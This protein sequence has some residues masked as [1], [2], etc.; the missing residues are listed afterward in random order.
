V[1][2]PRKFGAAAI[3]TIGGDL[4][5][6]LDGSKDQADYYLG[7]DG[8]PTH[9]RVELHGR[10]FQRLGI[11]TLD[12]TSFERLAAGHHPT[13]GVRLV[14]TSHIPTTGLNPA[15]GKPLVRGGSHVP[16]IDCNLSP[17]KS[18]SALLPF[19]SAEERGELEQAHLADPR[20]LLGVGRTAGCHDRLV[21]AR[22]SC[23]PPMPCSGHPRPIS[24]S[25]SMPGIRRR[26]EPDGGGDGANVTRISLSVSSFA[27]HDPVRCT[28]VLVGLLA[29]HGWAAGT[30]HGRVC[31]FE[32]VRPSD[33][34]DLQQV[35]IRQ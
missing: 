18:V 14:Q 20:L 30:G 23:V 3:A 22:S 19:V 24:V 28:T 16:G 27:A 17:P 15:T 12:R 26:H 25:L 31:E 9:S 1:F 32:L 21:C 4:F 11:T 7:T 29:W 10:L 2:S 13:T 35:G 34:I 5:N 6:Y 8:T 33:V